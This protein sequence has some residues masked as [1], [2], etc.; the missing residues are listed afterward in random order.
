[1]SDDLFKTLIGEEEEKEEKKEPIDLPDL[2]NM[3]L[4]NDEDDEFVPEQ[5]IEKKAVA[6]EKK[7]TKVEPKPM[8][9]DRA[10][11]MTAEIDEYFGEELVDIFCQMVRKFQFP[12]TFFITACDRDKWEYRKNFI[13]NR[14]P[15]DLQHLVEFGTHGLRHYPYAML[16]AG[17]VFARH[18]G[19][20]RKFAEYHRAPDFMLD[21]RSETLLSRLGFTLDN[22]IVQDKASVNKVGGMVKLGVTAISADTHTELN[23][24]IIKHLLKDKFVVLSFKVSRTGCRALNDILH[25][26]RANNWVGLIIPMRAVVEG[27]TK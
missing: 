13:L 9:R 24:T 7:P 6:I 2:T 17:D 19:T 11:V 15:K 27:M 25:V 4:E 14:I 26:L 20:Q 23:K 22:S 18:M 21:Q 1:M 8:R 5:K 12:M 16:E 10:I 3:I